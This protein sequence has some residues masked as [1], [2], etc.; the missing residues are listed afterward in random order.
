MTTNETSEAVD[1]ARLR[2]VKCM[3]CGAP[4]TYTVRRGR[5]P[6]ACEGAHAE[7]R[8]MTLR[9]ESAARALFAD[10]ALRQEGSGGRVTPKGMRMRLRH[11]VNEAAATVI[12]AA[13][14]AADDA[15]ERIAVGGAK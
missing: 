2:T 13:Q 7:F 4:I 6:E 8:R 10:P 15:R 11:A 14:D 9:W 12:D 5:P 3:V 1:V